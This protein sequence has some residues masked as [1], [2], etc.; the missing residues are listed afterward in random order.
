VKLRNSPKQKP[1]REKI[2]ENVFQVDF[3]WK[4][5]LT[6]EWFLKY[7]SILPEPPSLFKATMYPHLFLVVHRTIGKNNR[8]RIYTGLTDGKRIYIPINWNG[9]EKRHME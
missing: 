7:R 4:S 8:T 9:F 3:L 5:P 1:L 2:L 6:I